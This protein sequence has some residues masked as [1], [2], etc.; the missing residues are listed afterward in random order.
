MGFWKSGINR[1]KNGTIRPED[2]WTN[3]IKEFFESQEQVEKYDIVDVKNW[4]VDVEGSIHL[5]ESD[6]YDGKLFFKIGKLTGNLYCHCRY[7]KPSVIPTELGG[8]IVFVLD[9][10][11]L[12]KYRTNTIG[13]TNDDDPFG[14]MQFIPAKAPSI[15]K[16]EADLR[17]VLSD[18]VK[19]DYD[20]DIDKIKKE[21]ASEWGNR[22]EY[23]LVL[24]IIDNEYKINHKHTYKN[25]DDNDKNLDCEFYVVDANSK[26]KLNISAIEKAVYILYI[27]HKEGLP[28][29]LRTSHLNELRKIYSQI[30]GRVQDDANGIMG[31]NFAITTLNGYRSGIRK[32]L[33]AKFSNERVIDL[34]AIEGYKEQPCYVLKA[35][36]EIREQI[37]QA[38]DL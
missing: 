30:A 29:N 31:N 12:A 7:F 37:R 21:L 5:F 20:F 1:A 14:G 24:E 32:A 19:Y 2:D 17:A 18:S 13:R 33:K 6:L 15:S 11:E 23:Q 28:L 34:F 3:Q 22:D 16:V 9:E 38:F 10:E 8:E 35:T 27:M 25:L 4:V 26:T 36:D